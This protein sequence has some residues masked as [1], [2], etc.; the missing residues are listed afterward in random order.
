MAGSIFRRFSHPGTV[1]WTRLGSFAAYCEYQRTAAAELLRRRTIEH[2]LITGEERFIVNGYCAVCRRTVPFEADYSW[3]YPIDGVLTPNWREQLRCPRCDL[4]NRMRAAVH[5]FEEQIFASFRKPAIYLTEQKTPLFR[6]LSARYRGLVG[7]EYFGD[8]VAFG[9]RT[10]EGV[11]NESLTRLTFPDRSFDY[12]LSFE[13]LEHVPRFERAL[14]ET[15]RVLRPGGVF[16]FSAPFRPDHQD[17]LVRA[18]VDESGEVRH[19]L[20]P[21]YHGDPLQSAGCLAFYQF[22]WELFDQ[23]RAAG[24]QEANAYS[25]WSRDFGYL[26]DN[27]C[28]FMAGKAVRA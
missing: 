16:L 4:N 12:V 17:N 11:R 15:W 13:V 3:A 24:F 2:E 1:E 19:L 20:P 8:A 10:S 18:V 9:E 26:G 23:V 28:L 14:S 22:G 27:L 7:S 6:C 21:E 5:L 25:F